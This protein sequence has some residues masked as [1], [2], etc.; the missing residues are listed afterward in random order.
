[1]I[2][3]KSLQEDFLQVKVKFLKRRLLYGNYYVYDSQQE[4]NIIS[5]VSEGMR[6]FLHSCSIYA[7]VS[8]VTLS[9]HPISEPAYSPVLTKVYAITVVFLFLYKALSPSLSLFLREVLCIIFP[10]MLGL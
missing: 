10:S 5:W 1:M 9:S 2:E 6:A 4:Y 8:Q 7:F 3:K